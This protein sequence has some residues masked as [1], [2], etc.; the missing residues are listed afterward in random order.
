MGGLGPAAGH[1]DRTGPERHQTV[2]ALMVGKGA[3][4]AR[5]QVEA[6]FCREMPV[7]P[8]LP[9]LEHGVGDGSAGTVGHSATDRDGVGRALGDHQP[10][11]RPLRPDADERPR[12]LRRRRRRMGQSAGVSGHGGKRASA[13]YGRSSTGVGRPPPSTMSKT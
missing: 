7:G 6:G 3:G 12:G 4:K 13:L 2:P 5:P 9:K 11:G 10:G 1:G 8:C